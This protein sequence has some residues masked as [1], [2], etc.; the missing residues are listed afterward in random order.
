MYESKEEVEKAMLDLKMFSSLSKSDEKEVCMEEQE[1]EIQCQ[2]FPEHEA[3]GERFRRTLYY[4]KLPGGGDRPSLPFTQVAVEQFT[5]VGLDALGEKL[6]RLD[7]TRAADISR[8][9][10]AGPNSL[11]LALLYLD[12]LRKRNPDYLTTVSSADLFLV[13][14]LVASKFLHDDGEEDE[15]FNDEWANSGGIDTKELN[16]LELGFLSALDWRIYVGNDEFK[17]AVTKVETDIALREISTRGWASYSD[18]NVLASNFGLQ[19]IWSLLLQSTLQVTVVC[20]TAYAA[21]FLTLLS[22]VAVLSRTPVGPAAVTDSVQTLASSLT[23]VSSSSDDSTSVPEYLTV[24]EDLL[25]K[26]QEELLLRPASSPKPADLLRASLLVTTLTSSR[27][28]DSDRDSSPGGSNGS[29]TG[30]RS[31]KKLKGVKGYS[32]A[33]DFDDSHID[34]GVLNQTRAQ[35]LAEYSSLD[36]GSGWDL[37][38]PLGKPTVA[39]STNKGDLHGDRSAWLRE[40]SQFIH[41]STGPGGHVIGEDVPSGEAFDWA[42]TVRAQALG[43]ESRDKVLRPFFQFL[44]RCPV[45]RWGGRQTSWLG[46]AWDHNFWMGLERFNRIKA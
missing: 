36:V 2:V 26:S 9:A 23:A 35:W 24:E 46:Q 39:D 37:K 4:G 44:G 14:L 1:D 11:V 31:K 20:V 15:V 42:E 22:T 18:L 29:L 41:H 13:S 27:M 25:M 8:Q 5:G 3:M 16:K 10:C 40:R 45:L 12:R 43:E 30:H 17:T 19:A 38:L 21:S 28:S 6:G 34:R 7:M 33:D 32:D